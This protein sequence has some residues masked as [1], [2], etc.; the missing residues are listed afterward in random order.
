MISVNPRIRD[1]IHILGVGSVK[2]LPQLYSEASI[3]V[4][5]SINEAFGSVLIESLASGTPVVGT[6]SGGIA[7]IITNPLIGVLYRPNN[8]DTLPTNADDLCDAMIQALE[9]AKDGE[10]SSRCREHAGRFDWRVVG[11]Q[12]EEVYKGVINGGV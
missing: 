12:F 9:L 6:D 4:L 1:S 7:E 11:A 5:P 3:F 8:T 2:R 10:T